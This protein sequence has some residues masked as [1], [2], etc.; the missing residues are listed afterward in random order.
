VI[1]WLL[2][3]PDKSFLHT[4]D[5]FSQWPRP[6][7]LFHSTQVAPLLEFLVPFKLFCLLVVLCGNLSKTVALSQLTQFWQIPRHRT[8]YP[9]SSPCFIMTAP[10][11]ETCKYTL[12][13]IIQANMERFSTYWYAPFC[14]VFF[15]CCAAK[16]VSS[17]GTCQ[18]PFIFIAASK[19]KQLLSEKTQEE[20]SALVSVIKFVKIS[21]MR[22][23]KGK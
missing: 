12:V 7:C 3:A 13:P 23:L 19:S 4:L 21:F 1:C 14:N 5:S 11:G 16:F 9:L 15:G 17:G 22:Y 10:S 6:A 20:R 2:K 8:L 18:L